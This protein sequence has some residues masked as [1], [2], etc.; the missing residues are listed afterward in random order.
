MAD[1]IVYL[2][3]PYGRLRKP[4]GHAIHNGRRGRVV[5]RKPEAKVVVVHF[6]G[7]KDHA[8]N[9]VDVPQDWLSDQPVDRPRGLSRQMT[10][11]L[12]P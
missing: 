9:T 4:D 8:K 3:S 1:I 12:V 10:N 7:G 6:F 11:A 5:E 2:K